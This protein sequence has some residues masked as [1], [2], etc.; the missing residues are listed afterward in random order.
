MYPASMLIGPLMN[1]AQSA[2]ASSAGLASAG[3]AAADMPKFAGDVA[4]AMK[5]LGGGAGL[6][7][8]A[9][10]GKARLVG[11]M[12]VPP[13]WQGSMPKG[14]ASGA[15]AGL[16][17]LPA[18]MAAAGPGGMGM[19]PM[20]MPMGAGAGAGMPGGMMGRGGA[21]AHVIQQ[22]PSVVPRTGVG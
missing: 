16:G 11:A 3:L 15:M 4:P 5:G 2:N 6:G 19:M 20:P 22:R 14:M 7:A 1:A 12:S 13:T 10:L 9:D 17:A 8:A 21:A 18:E